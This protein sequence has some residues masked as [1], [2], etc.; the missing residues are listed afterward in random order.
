[1]T[2]SDPGP[3]SV[4]P[5]AEETTTESSGSNRG[6]TRQV[7]MFCV[8][9]AGQTKPEPLASRTMDEAVGSISRQ[10]R[11]GAGAVPIVYIYQLVAAERYVPHSET[12]TVEQIQAM[13]DAP[14][15]TDSV[16]DG[17]GSKA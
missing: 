3:A 13:L 9:R 10:V 12:L 8:L 7:P 6:I 4:T 1:M 2:T 14:L 11:I 15:L 5:P 16:E 17:P